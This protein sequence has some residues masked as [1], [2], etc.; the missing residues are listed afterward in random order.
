MSRAMT[1]NPLIRSDF[2]FLYVL[3]YIF[4]VLY[5]EHELYRKKESF[6]NSLLCIHIMEF[7]S[8]IKIND[9]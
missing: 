2:N 6:K 9:Y 7:Y 3:V 5:N 1:P 4:Q 8:E